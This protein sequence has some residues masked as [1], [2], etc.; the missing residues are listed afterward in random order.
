MTGH[1]TH[2]W[3]VLKTPARSPRGV[4]A[5]QVGTASQIGANILAAGGN[6][7][8]A[9][10]ATAFALAT[11]EP[12]NSGL[13]GC[14]FMLVHR[15]GEKRAQ[16]ISFGPISPI[17]T[18]PSAYPL[19]GGETKDL[20]TWPAV[21]EGRNAHGPLSFATPGAVDGLGLAQEKWGRLTLADVLAPAIALADQGLPIDWFSS[22]RIANHAAGLRRYPT[23]RDIYLP[24]GLPPVASLPMHYLKQ[25]K[26]A[27][28]MRQLARSGRRDFYE[29]QIAADIAADCAALGSPLGAE[30]LASYH[31]QILDPLEI[32]YRGHII[33]AV[34]GLSAGPTLARVLGELEG[35][36]LGPQP[37]AR[38][39]TAYADH[40]T[41]AYQERLAGLGDVSKAETCTTHLV[42]VDSEGTMVSVT[43]TLLSIF[44]SCVVLPKTGIL[45]NNGMFWF[46]P[47]PGHANSIGARKRPLTNMCPV[48]AA[49]N[50]E[51]V[52]ATGASGGR[53][54]MP[55][56]LQLLSF[57]LDFGMDVEQAGHYPRIDASGTG[58]VDADPRLDPSILEALKAAGHQV[59]L[60]SNNVFPVNYA[61]PSLIQREKSGF[62]GLADVS[63]PWAA[64]IAVS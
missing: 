14:G 62:A 32:P 55:A 54:I 56:V 48:I 60:V 45:M 26:L 11:I 49:R 1:I 52:L 33:Q 43:N 9:A 2:N 63:S 8:D 10:V 51:P 6:A 4:V 41:A 31:A 18:D 13:G 35:M 23:S 64:A 59:D 58:K 39:F 36:D 44:G 20:F 24:D 28:T 46:D 42:A 29:G 19:V 53:R 30:D 15:A 47:R 57:S 16:V 17:K 7:V 50:G 61:C 34:P 27:E 37:Q 40:L 22:L 38:A 3:T 25:G 5:S 12:G 21:L